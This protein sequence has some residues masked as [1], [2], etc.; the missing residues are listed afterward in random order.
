M[1]DLSLRQHILDELEFDPRVNAAEIGVIVEKGIVTLTGH[2]GNYAERE[3]AE[4]VVSRVKGVRG[5][6]QEIEVR[7]FGAA[8]T[9]DDDI[10]AR[11]VKMLDW[12]VCVPKDA[13]Q[14][15]VFKGW[16][17]LTG[18]V[19]WQYQKDAAYAS[20]KSLAGVVGVSNLIEIK[21]KLSA[22]DVKKR[23]EDAFERD[24][25]I[26]SNHISVDVQGRKVILS[27]KVATWS[28][29]RAAERAAW[30]APGISTLE[31]RLTIA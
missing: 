23:I 13:V 15:R 19:E 20:V 3:S 16:I 11:A 27:G 17:T 29:R 1:N 7:I 5:I 31:D 24:A 30:S 8:V 6:A 14:V 25:E 4:R 26:E 10:A 28:Q 21:P 2:V 22:T 18:K 12:D 9:D